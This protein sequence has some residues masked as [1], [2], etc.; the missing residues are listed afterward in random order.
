VRPQAEDTETPATAGKLRLRDAGTGGIADCTL[1]IADMRT[2]GAGIQNRDREGAGGRC[3]PGVGAKEDTRHGRHES[4]GV[5][6]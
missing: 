1:Q 3:L 4:A 5:P 2:Q 6:R